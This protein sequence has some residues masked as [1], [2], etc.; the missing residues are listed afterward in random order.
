MIPREWLQFAPVPNDLKDGQKWNIFLSYRS[1]NR[2][3]VFN[4]YDIL[5]KLVFKIF[6]DQY[7]LKPG[8]SL[9]RTLEDGLQQS[10]PGILVWS[11]A[12]KDSEWVKN[13]YDVLF[14]K[15]TC[16]KQF[17]FIP[18]KI[19]KVDLPVFAKTKLFEILV[20][21]LMGQMAEMF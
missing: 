2:G 12:A 11:N 3:R 6:L 15:S 5:T 13:K 16:N 9:V 14:N 10:Q 18:V 20:S 17:Y 19:E 7:V 1:V 8:D 4:L 21:I